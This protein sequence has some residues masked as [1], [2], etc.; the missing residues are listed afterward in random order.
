MRPFYGHKPADGFHVLKD[1]WGQKTYHEEQSKALADD[2]AQAIQAT[3]DAA[4]IRRQGFQLARQGTVDMAETQE[5]RRLEA[6]MLNRWN[7]EDMRPIPGA[8]SRLV[9]FQTPLFNEAKKDSWGYIDLLGV[10]PDGLPVVVELK[11]SPP[12]TA[13]GVTSNPETP[14]RMLLE[15]AAYAV[16]LRKNWNERFREE[17]TAHLTD[18]KVPE[19]TINQIP[20]ELTTVP[21]VAAAPAAFWMEWLP[22]TAKGRSMG[23]YEEFCRLVDELGKQELPVSFVSISGEASFPSTLAVQPLEALPWSK[24]ALDF[25]KPIPGSSDKACL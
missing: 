15:A 22:F 18:L 25:A 20:S 24:Q 3:C 8:W 7:N 17:W 5:E 16:S 13:N 10:N 14:L 1:A 4:P 19:S 23:G 11:R 12:A 9:A 6:A 21:L 2:L